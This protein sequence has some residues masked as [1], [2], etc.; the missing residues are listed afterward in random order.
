MRIVFSTT[1]PGKVFAAREDMKRS[2]CFYV[3]LSVRGY[4]E[5]IVAKG[6]LIFYDDGIIGVKRKI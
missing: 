1:V 2:L 4:Y 5:G 3:G 6:T